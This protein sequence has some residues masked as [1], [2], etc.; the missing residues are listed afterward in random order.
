MSYSKAD[1]GLDLQG[2]LN[3][4]YDPQRIGEWAHEMYMLH[5]GKIDADLEEI[6]VD[7]FVLEEGPEFE[8]PESQLKQLAERLIY[9]K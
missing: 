6:I 5:C 8:I 4:G 3:R 1:F 2:Q 7:L 9:R